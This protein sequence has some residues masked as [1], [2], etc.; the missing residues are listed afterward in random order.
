MSMP[1]GA[2]TL[3]YYFGLMS[4]GAAWIAWTSKTREAAQAV[5]RKRAQRA[6]RLG[7]LDVQVDGDEHLPDGGYVAVYNETSWPDALAF[8]ATLW[9]AYLDRGAGAA[10]FGKI[11]FMKAASGLAG[12]ALVPRG[13]RA[14]VD[15]VLEDLSAS[16]RAGERV[17]FG[18][19]G[20]MSGKDG[21]LRFKQGAALLAIRAGRPLV[22][23]AMRGGHLL[24]PWGTLNLSPGTVRI[25]FGPPLPVT[26]LTDDDARELADQAQAAVTG[27]YEQ[28]AAED[29][30]ARSDTGAVAT[31]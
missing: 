22:P 14:G 28:L 4:F 19:E 26:G 27:L 10:E 1:R 30:R 18:G 6:L 11:P 25:R 5:V 15:R 8:N 12:V 31:S 16:L 21:V 24:L 29:S 3:G 7:G 2:L 23:M 13:D 9:G 17:A 20:R